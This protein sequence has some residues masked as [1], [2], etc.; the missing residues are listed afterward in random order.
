MVSAIFIIAVGLGTA[1]LLGLVKSDQKGFAFTLTV[2]ALAVM[3]WIAY[4]WTVALSRGTVEPA[5]ILTAGTQPPF[6]INLHIGLAEAWLLTV[7]NATGLLAAFYMRA[8]LCRLGKTRM[9]A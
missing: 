8:A 3:T 9:M 6:A 5:T 1:F 7:I 4:D 2:A